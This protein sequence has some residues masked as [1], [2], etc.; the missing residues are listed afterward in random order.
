MAQA[1]RR[2]TDLFHLAEATLTMRLEHLNRL[3]GFAARF[4]GFDGRVHDLTALGRAD[5]VK[6]YDA[7]REH[8][9]PVDYDPEREALRKRKGI[10]GLADTVAKLASPY[11]QAVALAL[12]DAAMAERALD[13]SKE[14]KKVAYRRRPITN[15][16]KIISAIS[17]AWTVDGRPGFLLLEDLV[18]LLMRE[19]E[20]EAGLPLDVMIGAIER[21]QRPS[22]AWALLIRGA[23]MLNLLRIVPLRARTLSL[24]K[25]RHW[26][27]TA[28]SAEELAAA[29]AA[30]LREWEGEINLEIPG[31]AM[32]QKRPF[33]PALIHRALVGDEEAEASVRRPLL[34]AWFMD[35][36]ARDIVLTP[37]GGSAALPSDY[38]FPRTPGRSSGKA[39]RG[40]RWL[41]ASMSAWFRRTVVRHATALRL[42]IRR[43]AELHG[44]LGLHVV[45]LLFG[46]YWVGEG[47][48]EQASLML[49]HGDV[50]FTV[51]LYSGRTEREASLHV[52][53]K[54]RA[55][56]A[57]NNEATRELQALVEAT[58]RQ[59]QAAEER[60]A[61]LEQQLQEVIR[62]NGEL[63]KLLAARLE[64]PGLT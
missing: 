8:N 16:C 3:A 22:H 61:A 1:A 43:L 64:K 56:S 12:G 10:D 50:G 18:E 24:L 52:G 25:R 30:A 63:M 51:R 54:A 44:A 17:T 39:R 32:K 2:G 14:A 47:M 31:T 35:G 57:A 48:T 37:P 7:W 58:A 42:D 5:L 6:R 28:V 23:T 41:P 60:A 38:V 34:K 20:L 13:C 9:P 4:A 21:G 53:R 33:S 62:Q 46:T 36:G 19:A 55:G 40:G 11:V 29:A 26:K 15:E 59:G 49:S 27:N 45:R